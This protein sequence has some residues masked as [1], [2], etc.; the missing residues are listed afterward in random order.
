MDKDHLIC[1]FIIFK[2]TVNT[3]IYMK[4][5]TLTLGLAAL[6][7]M[8]G[9]AQRYLGVAT[10]NWSGNNA[11]YLNPAN[12]ADSRH[13]FSIDLVSFN[14]GM[15]N[16]FYKASFGDLADIAKSDN[17]LGSLFDNLTP[18]ADG[19]YTL[20][21]PNV[22][23]RGPGFMA[24]INRKHS[25]AFTTRVRAMVQGHQLN[26]PLFQSV[27]NED[28][29]GSDIV[30]N[31]FT[32]KA[33]AFNFTAN[34]WSEFGLSY[35]VVLLESNK[36]QLKAGVTARYLRGSGYF[37]LLNQNLDLRYIA[38]SDSVEVTNT[39]FKYG[40]NINSFDDIKNEP[41]KSR[42]SGIGGDIGLVYEFRPN[43]TVS[44]YDM[45][46]KT[47]LLDASK[48]T[49]KLR[50][51]V[52]VTDLGVINY[53]ENNQSAYFRN[54]TAAPAYIVGRQIAE[55]VSNF[56]DFTTYLD[57][58]GLKADTLQNVKSKVHLPTS[59]IASIDYN[60]YQQIYVN[61]LY[62][63]NLVNRMKDF[64][65]SFYNQLT[66]TPRVDIRAFSLG[67]PVS[68]NTLNSSLVA[69]VG[70][71][72]GGLFFGSD[73][74]VGSNNYG[75]NFYFGA[76]VP[77][78]K[79]RPRDSDHDGVSNRLDKCK[80]EKGDWANKGCPNP[81][82]D[83]DG[84][85]DKD[86]KCPDIAGIAAANGCPDADA[87]GI[88]DADDACPDDAGIAA[89]NGCPDADG[90]GIPDYQDAC[91]QQAG[92]AELKGCPD[93]DK[94]GISDNEDQCPDQPGSMALGGCPDTDGDGIADNVDKCPNKP[95]T[96]DNFG[97]PEVSEATKKRLEIIG[98]A[99]QFE[100]GKAAIKKV[101]FVQLDEVVKILNNDM[102]YNME[103]EGHTDNVGKPEN[104]M[105]LSQERAD[106]V[107]NYLIAK[108]IDANRL[109]SV[110]HGDTQPVADNK[111]PAGRAKNRRVVMTLKLKQ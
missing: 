2:S 87:D 11:L 8:A 69:G 76:N 17:G 60:I 7:P 73:N 81:D 67:L 55:N 1:F 80:H 22:E 84:I 106:A 72:F 53:K 75:T 103:I 46:G 50:V 59:L 86:D 6:L 15:D 34:A 85:L 41:F 91:P 3:H 105:K 96:P 68:Y 92:L 14:F 109:T 29:Q 79:R 18:R 16:N 13:K 88:A 77:I 107:K 66:V 40:S 47:G 32:A 62:S 25:I 48:N 45:D 61:V 31:G 37:S 51:S 19:K 82:K 99:I 95:G 42:G 70:V 110:G 97:C 27:I 4:K 90:D 101:S 102:D 23:V 5:F 57:T 30:K 54:K 93:T 94:D 39:N 33:S 24:S 43:T 9:S 64:G 98:G 104:N 20:A 44:R 38:N 83:G 28:F 52:A 12:I 100:T 56:D 71:R 78:A 65:T 21:G 10:S 49:Y 58:K 111:T 108:G 35:G 36:H 74:L 89:L 63:A 26:A